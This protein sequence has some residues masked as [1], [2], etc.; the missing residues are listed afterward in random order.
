[1]T[2]Y[3]SGLVIVICLASAA[4]FSPPVAPYQ[5]ASASTISLGSVAPSN[6]ECYSRSAFLSSAFNTVAITSAFV[7]PSVAYAVDEAD[8]SSSS[9][10]SIKACEVNDDCVSTANIRDAKGSYR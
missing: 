10:R 7:F 2:M 6:D 4:A 3:G 8:S 1:M 5:R 9:T